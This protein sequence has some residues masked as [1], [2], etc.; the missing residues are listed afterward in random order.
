M[1]RRRRPAGPNRRPRTTNRAASRSSAMVTRATTPPR[2][3]SCRLD[4]QLPKRVNEGRPSHKPICARNDI[5]ASVSVALTACRGSASGLGATK[6]C[7]TVP[8]SGTH[9]QPGTTFSQSGAPSTPD[10][11]DGVR[12]SA[13]RLATFLCYTATFGAY[14]L[15]AGVEVARARER[16]RPD[17]P[18][19]LIATDSGMRPPMSTTVCTR[20]PGTRAAASAHR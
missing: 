7:G 6:T 10:I 16:A 5:A 17:A 13:A 14:A 20:R 15:H 19:E 11:G 18:L 3:I 12:L 9:R 4:H 8:H 1:S 2:G